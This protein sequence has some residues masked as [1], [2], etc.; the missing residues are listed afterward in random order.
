MMRIKITPMTGSHFLA[1]S[2]KIKS[3][4]DEWD[5]PKVEDANEVFDT[6]Y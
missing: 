5:A 1:L 3:A 4:A 6:S 2:I